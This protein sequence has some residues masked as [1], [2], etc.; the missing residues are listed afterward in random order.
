MATNKLNVL[1]TRPEKSG[2]GLVLK[3]QALEIAA[4]HQPL[5]SYQE[6][7]SSSSLIT[8]VEH[9][10]NPIVIFV[11]V[12]AVEF[13][14]QLFTIK[15]WQASSVIAVGSATQKALKALSIDAICPTLHTSEGLLALPVLDNVNNQD[16]IIV[17]G[18]GGREL[19][20]ERLTER[21]AN[22]QY[23]EVYQR[24]WLTF[25]PDLGQTW[26]QKK[27][28]T[29]VITSNA[30]LESIVNLIE[31]RDNYWQNTCL[32]IVASERIAEKA[33]ALGLKHVI[34]AHGANDE[35]IMAVIRQHGI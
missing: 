15:Q 10:Q 2:R 16:V 8:R 5:F 21:G 6:N 33:R 34:N 32:W 3:C 19:I 30:L 28:N 24:I 18:D 23:L 4:W 22:V 31:L 11:S 14:E 29:I 35:A 17:R 26:Q 9:T 1:I 13:A 25:A 20:A 12:A 27:I 7:I